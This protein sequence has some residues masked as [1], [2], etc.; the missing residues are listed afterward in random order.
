MADARVEAF[1][2]SMVHHARATTCTGASSRG[3]SSTKFERPYA[4]AALR[5]ACSSTRRSATTTTRRTDVSRASTWAASA[6]TP[7]RRRTCASSC[8]TATRWIRS[9]WSWLDSTLKPVAGGLA[10]LLLPPSALLR[11]AGRHGSDVSLRVALE[12]LLVKYGVNV[13]FSGHDHVYERIKP[14]KGIT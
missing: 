2:S 4:V 10:D 8:S 6:T 11:T 1:R 13:V 5:P 9:S 12:P 3:T 7:T 14:Q